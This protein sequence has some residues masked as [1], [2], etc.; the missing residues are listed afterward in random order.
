MS[1]EFVSR[2]VKRVIPHN[3]FQLL[4]VLGGY[5]DRDGGS[6]WPSIARMA[7]ET[8]R[9]KGTVSNQLTVLRKMGWLSVVRPATRT[10]PAEYRIEI[11][12]MPVRSEFEDLDLPILQI[13]QPAKQSPPATIH[14]INGSLNREPLQTTVH[15]FVGDSSLDREAT[16][17]TVHDFVNDGS[18]K[19]DPIQS[20]D[21]IN[22]DPLTDPSGERGRGNQG[23][24]SGRTGS[25]RRSGRLTVFDLD[26]MK[27]RVP[28]RPKVPTGSNFDP[29]DY[30]DAIDPL[31]EHFG[32]SHLI[33][34]RKGISLVWKPEVIEGVR[35]LSR[36]WSTPLVMQGDI[37]SYLA[38]RYS[39]LTTSSDSTSNLWYK[40]AERLTEAYEAGTRLAEEG[41]P[42]SA[43]RP[44]LS[45]DE[46]R[47]QAQDEAQ[48][49]QREQDARILSE[50]LEA[51]SAGRVVGRYG[52][53]LIAR[54]EA[55]QGVAV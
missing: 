6:V 35:H 27:G 30:P 29:L 9:S 46:R 7:H 49:L 52:Q 47:R 8:D 45:E 1:R 20:I 38:A 43:N 55:A 18:L 11:D 2:L 39:E 19:P 31:L 34:G 44:P 23:T 41:A 50:A 22:R 32:L 5:A 26:R 10:R 17:S 42:S 25:Y 12:R 4:I 15:D 21:P 14:P 54:Y 16:T 3:L 37:S 53:E 13:S 36:N 40:A 24:R 51:R 33:E 28:M 48:R